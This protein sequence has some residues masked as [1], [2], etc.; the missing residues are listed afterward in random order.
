MIRRSCSVSGALASSKTTATSALSSAD[1]VRNVAKYSC[2]DAFFD[3]R[4]IPAVS[5]NIHSSSSITTNSSTGSTVVPATLSTTARFSPVNAFSRL[6]LPTFGLPSS[7]TRC[8]P[9]GRAWP[10]PS[11]GKAASTTSNKSPLP[12]P[13]SAETVYGS[14]SP[15][16]QSRVASSSARSSSTLFA[17]KMTGT[18]AWR[19]TL[20][21]CSSA[22][23][24][25]TVAS[26]TKITTSLELIAASA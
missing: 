9:R 6:D 18:F 2:P 5:T 15:S 20:T 26:T 11:S 19:S 23:V 13:C 3:L 17:T 25:P 22:S 21:I 8:G 16:D 7:A 10:E 12:R 24:A 14:P 1:L 4:R